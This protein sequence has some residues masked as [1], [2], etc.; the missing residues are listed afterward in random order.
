MISEDNLNGLERP[1]F[2]KFEE[3]K[4]NIN[5]Q[6]AEDQDDLEFVEDI[7]A[8][9]NPDFSLYT[10]SIEMTQPNFPV[11]MPMLSAQP[12]QTPMQR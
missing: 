5:I 2:T 4:N 7:K 3:T 11:E 8:A 9:F 10:V 6:A 1:N 12:Y